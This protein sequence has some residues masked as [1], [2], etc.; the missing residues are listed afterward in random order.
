MALRNPRLLNDY[1]GNRLE[2][3]PSAEPVTVAEL[4]T[5]LRISGSDEDTYLEGLITEARQE[6]EDATGIAFITQTWQLT[7]DRWPAAREDWWDGER[8]AHINVLYDGNRQNYASVRLPRYPLQNV[9]TINVY[10]EDGSATA[11]NIADVFDIDTQ[12]IRGR[13]TIKRGATWPIALRASNAIEITYV[14]GYGAAA[15][16]LPAPLKRAVRQM[17]GYMYEHRGDCGGEDAFI[18]SGARDIL[19]RYRDIEV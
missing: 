19:G 3:G 15:S 18:A 1:Q 10:D 6:I 4:K 17:A 16:A 2:T 5:H 12:Q 7:L 13:L 8:E 9:T 11:V 14:A